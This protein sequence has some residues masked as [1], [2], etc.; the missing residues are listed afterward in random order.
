MRCSFSHTCGVCVCAHAW[1]PIC[2]VFRFVCMLCF[3]FFVYIL[4][5][6]VCLPVI[7]FLFVFR[8]HVG[9]YTCFRSYACVYCSRCRGVL[10]PYTGVH[11]CVH[12]F[13]R[14]FFALVYLFIIFFCLC[15]FFSLYAGFSYA[16]LFFIYIVFRVYV[17]FCFVFMFFFS[18]VFVIFFVSMVCV[19]FRMYVVSLL[20]VCISRF[21]CYSL[22]SAR[23]RIFSYTCYVSFLFIVNLIFFRLRFGFLFQLCVFFLVRLRFTVVFIRQCV[24][25]VLLLVCPPPPYVCYSVASSACYALFFFRLFG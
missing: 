21:V 20:C 7:T 6:F 22:L 15:A 11:A 10:F 13:A 12:A 9:C 17:F 1:A 19:C 2:I 16:L 18:S 5:F 23:V 14:V 3:F 4:F 25:F 8:L 24:F